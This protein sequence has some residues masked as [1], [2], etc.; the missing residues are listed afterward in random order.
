MINAKY[1]KQMINPKDLARRTL[2][3]P[4]QEKR[5]ELWYKS[6]FR[7]EE[8]TASFEVS[9]KGFHDFGTNEHYDVISFMQRLNHC[10]FKEAVD[11]LSK[12]YGL[13]ENEYETESIRRRIEEQRLAMKAYREKVENWYYSF[14]DLTEKAWDDNEACIKAVGNDEETLAILYDRQIFLGC[15]REELLETDTFE[16]KEKLRAQIT[17]EGLPQWM[18][19]QE[20][21]FSTLTT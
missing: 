16:E 9:D 10:S 1:L 20:I 5:N 2:G 4:K 8:R 18:K 21:Y 12:M 6:P 17:K 14:L 7:A 3:I 19:N 11:T 13:T 15:L